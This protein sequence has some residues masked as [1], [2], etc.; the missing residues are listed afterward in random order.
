MGNSETNESSRAAGT[1]DP[2]TDP[3][4]VLYVDDDPAALRTRAALIEQHDRIDVVTE[5]TVTAGLERLATA[6]IDCVLSDVRMPDRDGLAFL[7]RVRERDRRFPFILFGANPTEP[8]VR[9]ALA[10]GATDFVPKSVCTISYRLLT[11][12]I[13]VAVDHYRERRSIEGSTADW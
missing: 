1:A 12:R 5:S 3:I 6:E 8:L 9:E 7:D 4:R 2:S 10:A 13:V 11:H